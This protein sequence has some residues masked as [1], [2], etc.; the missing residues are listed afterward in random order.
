MVVG[1][2]KSRG[3]GCDRRSWWLIAVVG[4]GVCG[5]CGMTVNWWLKVR[6]VVSG[7]V[8]GKAGMRGG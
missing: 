8:G 6:L 1:A 4:A 7:V 5:V 3:N 2:N